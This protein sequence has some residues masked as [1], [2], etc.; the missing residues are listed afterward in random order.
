[1]TKEGEPEKL[2]ELILKLEPYIK[3][4]KP[5]LSKEIMEEISGFQWPEEYI[6]E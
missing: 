3:T 2:L 6:K 5:K 4:K 1:L